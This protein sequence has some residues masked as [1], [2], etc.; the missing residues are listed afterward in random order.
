M[1]GLQWTETQE[2]QTTRGVRA[3]TVQGPSAAHVRNNQKGVQT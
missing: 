3:G 2:D 1:N